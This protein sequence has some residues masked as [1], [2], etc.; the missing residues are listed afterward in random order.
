MIAATKANKFIVA[1]KAYFIDFPKSYYLNG[2]LKLEYWWNKCIVLKGNF[3][4][5]S[6][7]VIKF[8][9]SLPLCSKKY[10]KNYCNSN[11]WLLKCIYQYFQ[12]CIANMVINNNKIYIILIKKTNGEKKH[13]FLHFC[14]WDW[15]TF[16][17]IN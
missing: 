6:Y 11:Y 15:H 7:N 10:N 5:L 4:L 14:Q 12:W 8:V 16:R 2:L 3:F 1:T 13:F 17:L 9:Y